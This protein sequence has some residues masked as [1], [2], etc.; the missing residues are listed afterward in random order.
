[1]TFD[2]EGVKMQDNTKN[3]EE[4]K[5][6]GKPVITNEQWFVRHNGL[7]VGNGS[8]NSKNRPGTIDEQA[9][10]DKDLD[11]SLT[12]V[13]RILIQVNTLMNT[14]VNMSKN[15]FNAE[16]NKLRALQENKNNTSEINSVKSDDIIESS[17]K[18]RKIE[19]TVISQNAD[20][21]INTK[22]QKGSNLN[23]LI[24]CTIQYEFTNQKLNIKRDYKLTQHSNFEIWLDY[25]KTD[26]T[27]N[28]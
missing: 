2:Q 5:T 6:N 9:G 25:L 20:S 19:E 10:S 4:V 22:E 24:K 17:A 18:R 7:P 14:M 27:S 11:G 8:Q 23:R 12:K 13:E 28:D 3:P 26:L 1:M 16:K 21:C 15:T